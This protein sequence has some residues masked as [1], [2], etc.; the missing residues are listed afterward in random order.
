MILDMGYD[1]IR[2]GIRYDMGH[3]IYI[4]DMR[5]AVIHDMSYDGIY[6]MIS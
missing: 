6:D 2:Y 1:A 3:Y 5:Y 4:Y